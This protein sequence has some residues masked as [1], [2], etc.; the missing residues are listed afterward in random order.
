MLPECRPDISSKG[1]CHNPLHKARLLRLECLF[2]HGMPSFNDRRY[3]FFGLSLVN[4]YQSAGAGGSVRA[5][6]SSCPLT[7]TSATLRV[8]PDVS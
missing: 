5:S 2:S 1:E 3:N 7:A 6:D 8:S 4:A